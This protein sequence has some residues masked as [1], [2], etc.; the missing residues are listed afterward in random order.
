[1]AAYKPVNTSFLFLSK[2]LIFVIL[3]GENIPY[4][5]NTY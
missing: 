5:K 2:L 4:N 3:Y 1:M